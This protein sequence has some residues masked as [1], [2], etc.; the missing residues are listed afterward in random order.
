MGLSPQGSRHGQGGLGEV[1]ALPALRPQ[2]PLLGEWS[3]AGRAG[4]GPHRRPS[5]CV[6]ER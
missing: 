2:P 3:D 1:P 6:E 5:R 4:L